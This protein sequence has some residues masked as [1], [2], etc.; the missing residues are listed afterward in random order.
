LEEL[1]V[2]AF[3]QAKKVL[4]ASVLSIQ[5]LPSESPREILERLCPGRLPEL[6]SWRVAVDR[7]YW[8]W[9]WPIGKAKELAILPP[10]SGG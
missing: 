1:R 6:L 2:L 3:A 7:C 8:E 5:A 9:D 4:G 10:V